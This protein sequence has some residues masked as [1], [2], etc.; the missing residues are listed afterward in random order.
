MNGC[1]QGHYAKWTKT[2]TKKQCM[3]PLICLE[4][5]IM[6][7]ERRMVVAKVR[8]RGDRELLV[9]WINRV[10]VLKS[11]RLMGVDDRDGCTFMNVLTI[12]EWHT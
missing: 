10:S 1:P 6:E 7:T 11:E 4:Y 2:V 8:E 9:N 3:I 12:T 5:Q